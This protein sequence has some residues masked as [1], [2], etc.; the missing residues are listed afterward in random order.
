MFL[1]NESKHWKSWK[2]KVPGSVSTGDLMVTDLINMT[3][4][5]EAAVTKKEEQNKDNEQ[6]NKLQILKG[7]VAVCDHLCCDAVY[8]YRS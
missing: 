3:T 4:A 1:F 2:F 8:Y 5:S 7:K 6:N